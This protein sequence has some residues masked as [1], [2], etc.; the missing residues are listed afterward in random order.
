MDQTIT[1]STDILPGDRAVLGSDLGRYLASRFADNLEL[2][3]NQNDNV[4]QPSALGL[5]VGKEGENKQSA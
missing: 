3:I 5:L 4:W 1:H 2:L